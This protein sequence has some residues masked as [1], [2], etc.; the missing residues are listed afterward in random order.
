[1]SASGGL[2]AALIFL[3]ALA[4]AAVLVAVGT[5]LYPPSTFA[6]LAVGALGIVGAAVVALRR[7]STGTSGGGER[8]R[9]SRFS[10]GAWISYCALVVLT[11]HFEMRFG[12]TWGIVAAFASVIPLV[13]LQALWQDH[14]ARSPRSPVR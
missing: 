8:P 5:A 9:P 14:H 13:F 2:R 1:M 6:F 3:S 10:R 4:A 7:P 12:R 11:R